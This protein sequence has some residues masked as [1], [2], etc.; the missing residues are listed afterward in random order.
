MIRKRK[1]IPTLRHPAPPLS[2]GRT[3]FW[4][5]ISSS[6]VGGLYLFEA[7]RLRHHAFF[8][9]PSLSGPWRSIAAIVFG[10]LLLAGGILHLFKREKRPQWKPSVP[11]DHCSRCGFDLRS[12]TT[13]RCSECG[14]WHGKLPAR[15]HTRVSE[16]S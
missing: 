10:V 16:N 13:V 2:H 14:A 11:G 5:G 9:F 7:L 3:E 15:R 4:V 1:Q 6:F 8:L 12:C